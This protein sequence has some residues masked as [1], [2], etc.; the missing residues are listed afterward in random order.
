M[1]FI[2]SKKSVF[3]FCLCLLSIASYAQQFPHIHAHAHNDYLHQHPLQDALDNGFI[4]VEA[5][6][7]LI[8]GDLYVS[9]QPPGSTDSGKTLRALYLDP[10]AER[11]EEHQGKVY[12]NYEGFFYLMIDIKSDGISTS[13][14]LNEQLKQYRSF[15]S[16]VQDTTEEKGKPVKIFLSGNRTGEKVQNI[17]N[18]GTHLFSLDGRPED[19]GKHIPS[20]LMPVVSDNYYKFLTWKGVGPVNPEE[21]SRLE[22]FIRQARAE[23]KKTRLWGGPDNPAIWKYLLD[24]GVDLIN[25]DRLHDLAVFLDNYKH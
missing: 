13:R 5:D 21:A 17:L 22:K 7:Y 19:L 14:V 3:W 15:I 24:Q 12:D 18:G 10:L 23:N 9:H 2:F 11:I 4:S 6:V 1:R 20:S 25:T 8:G 16:I